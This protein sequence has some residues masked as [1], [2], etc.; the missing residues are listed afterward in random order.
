MSKLR[1]EKKVKEPEVTGLKL[2]DGTITWA[3]G[4]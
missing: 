4:T 2:K 3:A 1:K